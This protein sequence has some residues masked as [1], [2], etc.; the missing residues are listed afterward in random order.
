MAFQPGV[1]NR[2][3]EKDQ[4]DGIVPFLAVAEH[5]SFTRA[6]LALNVSPTAVS[7]AIQQLERRSAVVLFQRTTRSVS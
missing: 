2:R 6:A 3:M 7:K 1:N 5:L 4:L